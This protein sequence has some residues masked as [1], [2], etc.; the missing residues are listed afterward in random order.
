MIVVRWIALPWVVFQF[1]VYENPYPPGYEALGWSIIGLL[2]VGNAVITLLHRGSTGRSAARAIA[3]GGIALD[4][5]VI[6]GMV[7][8]YAFDQESALWAI[9]FILPLEG[10]ITFQ[11]QGALAAWGISALIYI[12]R[13]FYG[14]DRFDYELQFNSITYRMGIG[15]II[16]LVAG[17]M[18]RDLMRQR[19]LLAEA[20]T[21]LKRVDQLRSAL[22]S[23]L[24]H[25]VRSPLTVIRGSIGTILARHDRLREE[26]RTALLTSADRQARRLEALA[27]DLLDL[28][29]LEAGRL[30]LQIEELSVAEIVRNALSY[31]ENGNDFDVDVQPDLVARADPQRLEQ[32][33]HN[34][35]ANA[36]RHGQPPFAIEAARSDGTVN[37]TVIDHGPGVSDDA[38][39]HLFEPFHGQHAS[40]S[41]GYGLAIVSA[42]AEAQGGAVAY[43]PNE[44]SGARFC[45]SL[46]AAS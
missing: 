7:W 41:V 32:I 21:E 12:G 17:L 13:E 34:L 11:L 42:L 31:I 18:A 22:I 16:G 8:L 39:P 30:D 46:P 1:M 15:L 2:A 43:E 3:V 37:I 36:V 29:R 19:T 4:I 20:V 6:S 5:A 28:A 25:D 14:S 26:D 44:P 38:R 27:T 23:T 9:V 24:G 45:V 35:A 10:A 33:L 40:G